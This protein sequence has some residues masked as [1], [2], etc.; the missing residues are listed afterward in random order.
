[1][2]GRF[3]HA[4]RTGQRGVSPRRAR[5]MGVLALATLAAA[6][7]ALATQRRML[8]AAHVDH[9]LAA[10]ENK[11]VHIVERA[12]NPPPAAQALAHAPVAAQAAGEATA[13]I[14]TCPACRLNALPSVKAFVYDHAKTFAP[15]LKVDFQF[16]EDPRMLLFVGAKQVEVIDLAVRLLLHPLFAPSL[17][18]R[19]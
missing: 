10:D 11:H 18:H 4:L 1:M 14:I 17:R 13:R 5:A 15:A 2:A 7:F 3:A 6:L 8:P 16:G 9:T 19:P 12:A